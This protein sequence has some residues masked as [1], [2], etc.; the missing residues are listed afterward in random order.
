MRTHEITPWAYKFIV[1][2]RFA[3]GTWYAISE[4]DRPIE[5]KP[6]AELLTELGLDGWELI[7][8][9]PVGETALNHDQMLKH[10][11]KRPGI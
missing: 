2:E 1:S 8:V 7:A 9:V 3:T 5:P 10:I 6:M 11:F 4:D